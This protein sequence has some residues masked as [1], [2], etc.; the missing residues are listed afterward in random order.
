LI[1]KEK[2]IGKIIW[3][4]SRFSGLQHGVIVDVIFAKYSNQVYEAIIKPFHVI[5]GI[6]ILHLHSA[7]FNKSWGIMED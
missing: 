4:K 6:S 7:S 3:Y 5:Y 2:M 1:D